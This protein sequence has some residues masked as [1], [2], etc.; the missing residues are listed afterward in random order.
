[1]QNVQELRLGYDVDPVLIVSLNMRGVQLDSA[2]NIA[3]RERLLAAAKSV[4]GVE[5]ASR[6]TAVPFWSTWSMGLF[7][8]GIDTV[9]RLGQFDLN[10]VTPEYFQTLGTRIVRGRGIT[11]DDTEHAPGA[12]VVSEAMGKVLWPGRDPM[13]Q[14]ARIGSDTVPCTYVVGIAENIKEQ[15][16]AADSGYYYYLSLPQRGPQRGGLFVRTRGDAEHFRD[17]VRTRL[18]REMPGISYVTVTP[19]NEIIGSQKRSW[20]LGSTMFVAFGALALVLA[21]IGLYSVIAYNVTQRTHELGVRRALGAQAMHAVRLVVTDGL[22]LAAIG[23]TTGAVIA[24]WAGRFVQPLLFDVSPRDPLVFVLV[25]T[26]LVLV[27]IA[28]RW[29]PALRE[30]RVD[31]NV[32]LRS[33]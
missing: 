5:T 18:Q 14:C 15:S 24:F 32:A 29:F 3:L 16:L 13:G 8:E 27:A 17:A 11:R 20:Q 22:R 2:Q 28:A 12:M 6:Q 7:V 30:S 23:V 26:L 31:P 21:A 10:A 25:A 1:M 33:E 19:F 9:S 4:P